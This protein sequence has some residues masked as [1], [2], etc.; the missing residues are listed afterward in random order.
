LL[1]G[2]LYASHSQLWSLLQADMMVSV[3]IPEVDALREA[4]ASTVQKKISLGLSP[5]LLA[6]LDA[7]GKKHM[8][9]T[10]FGAGEEILQ[11]LQQDSPTLDA[12]LLLEDE[13]HVLI[14]GSEA[15]IASSATRVQLLVASMTQDLAD[16]LTQI[17]KRIAAESRSDKYE[18]QTRERL[19]L[20]ASAI[21]KA[22][23]LGTDL[24]VDVQAEAAR[25]DSGRR[26]AVSRSR[27]GAAA[28]QT[29]GAAAG[30]SRRPQQWHMPK[31][32][33]SQLQGGSAKNFEQAPTAQSLTV[34]D[35]SQIEQSA[36]AGHE[37]VEV[38]P[39][40]CWVVSNALTEEECSALVDSAERH[41]FNPSAF[42]AGG[43]ANSRTKNFYDLKTCELIWSRL[44]DQLLAEVSKTAPFNELRSVHEAWRVSKYTPGQFF[45]PHYD[46]SY[47]RG[48]SIDG[49]DVSNENGE[50]GEVSSHTVLVIL[51]DSYTG[52][53]TRFWP[54]GCYD[55][56]IDV[57][58][59]KGSLL[60]FQ[61][62]DLLHEGC[63]LSSGQKIVAQGALMRAP[64][65][66][67]SKYT[68]TFT[69]G[70]RYGP[71][72]QEEFSDQRF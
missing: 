32:L 44:P 27:S 64:V 38:L 10:L 25:F 16:K 65:A 34:F 36:A 26:A 37:F 52:G 43:R 50:H 6:Q 57:T 46:E 58:G 24:K 13:G 15:D 68:P 54:T 72:P 71:G 19:G 33:A 61:Q 3:A 62:L 67:V 14:R 22:V 1:K 63:P 5:E 17:S 40:R 35:R 7:R 23:E 21:P 56:A 9:S 42:V 39:G 60:V 70:F 53:A 49:V 69:T 29:D 51:T 31:S 66:E 41:G 30:V 12:E 28:I 59:P 47:T 8:H 20:D 4:H 11:F 55:E 45:R 2:V 18:Q 48:C